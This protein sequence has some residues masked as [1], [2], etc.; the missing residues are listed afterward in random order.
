MQHI[1]KTLFSVNH[2]TSLTSREDKLSD[3]VND[4]A[5]YSPLVALIGLMEESV[6]VK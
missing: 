3:R 6:A 5:K 2:V 4:F 1:F